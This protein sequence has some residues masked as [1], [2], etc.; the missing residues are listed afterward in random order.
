MKRSSLF[1]W[2]LTASVPDL[3]PACNCYANDLISEHADAVWT[4]DK[5]L[6]TARH[7]TWFAATATALCKAIRQPNVD[8]AGGAKREAVTTKAKSSDEKWSS[9]A[10]L[11]QMIFFQFSQCALEQHHISLALFLYCELIRRTNS[12]NHNPANHLTGYDH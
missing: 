7:Q 10:C 12:F 1:T 6:E 9:T 2:H 4:T 3:L 8:P 5:R 11:D